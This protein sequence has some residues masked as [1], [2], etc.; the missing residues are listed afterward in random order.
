VVAVPTDEAVTAAA[1]A[2]DVGVL[3]IFRFV[4][5]AGTVVH[6]V[7]VNVVSASHA[8]AVRRH[9]R[10]HDHWSIFFQ[11]PVTGVVPIKHTTAD[12]TP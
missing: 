7:V 11:L 2:A 8:A 12:Q 3:N 1:A 6:A 10:L 9:V 5:G 4:I